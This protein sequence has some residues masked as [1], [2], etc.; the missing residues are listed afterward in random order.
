V[1]RRLL[2]E[3][4]AAEILGTSVDTV[5]MRAR[6]GSVQSEK[7]SDGRVYVWVDDDSPETKPRPGGEPTALIF[8]MKKHIA[9]LERELDKARAANR[10]NW[11]IILALTSRISE[12]P[13]GTPPDDRG[14]P[15]AAT[16]EPGRAEEEPQSSTGGPQNGPERLR[17]TAELPVRGSLTL[18]WWRR[19]FG[20]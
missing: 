1:A 10:E 9:F 13:A 2:T 6:S 14:S 20:G 16:V 17:G 8:E 5:R 11:R 15:K 4:E 19:V 3:G 18:P 12:L 7:D